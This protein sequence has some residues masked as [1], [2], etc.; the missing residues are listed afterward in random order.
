MKE[1]KLHSFGWQCLG[2]IIEYEVN[3]IPLRFLQHQ[4]DAAP[5]LR[6]IT[7]NLLKL[8]AAANKWP[9]DLF[10][11]PNSGNDLMYRLT[12]AYKLFFYVWNEDYV[13]L[14]AK[15]TETSS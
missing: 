11:L 4:E 8:N 3:S 9:Q 10:V 12:E 6:V 15:A 1:T 13:P 5:L 2:M 14:I 7:L